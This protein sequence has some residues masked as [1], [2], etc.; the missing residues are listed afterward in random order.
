[1][2]INDNNKQTKRRQVCVLTDWQSGWLCE[3]HKYLHYE[4][5]RT[6]HQKLGNHQPPVAREEATSFAVRER[7]TPKDKGKLDVFV[8]P[9]ITAYMSKANITM[10]CKRQ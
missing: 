8:I 2:R 6:R 7:L 4:V 3:L 10:T 9:V 1:M 5:E